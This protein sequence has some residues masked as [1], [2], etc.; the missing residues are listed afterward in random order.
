MTDSEFEQSVRPGRRFTWIAICVLAGTLSS[1]GLDGTSPFD[2]D[3]SGTP[4]L[5]E[6]AF[7]SIPQE[8][9]I[10]GGVGRDGIPALR[11]PSLVPSYHAEATYIGEA[12]RVIGIE[13]DGGSSRCRTTFSG[14]TR[15]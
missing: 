1:C 7:C 6:E 9:I 15:S 3:G 13:A 5:P 14:G 10:S 8:L 4:P 11:N 12:D 2:G